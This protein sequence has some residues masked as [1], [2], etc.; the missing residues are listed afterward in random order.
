[1][2]ESTPM[3]RRGPWA[4]WC[5]TV[6][7]FF[8]FQGQ[9][10]KIRLEYKADSAILFVSGA[11]LQI[12]G[13]LFLAVLFT[14][15]PEVA[16][17]TLWELVLMLSAIY[18]TEGIVSFG[19]EGS[20]NLSFLVHSGEMERFLL[21]PV[22]PA[23]QIMTFTLGIHGL[24]N[25]AIGVGLFALAFQ[26]VAIVWDP[27]KVAFVPVFVVSAAALRTAISFASNCSAFW[28]KGFGN[29][30]P[31]MVHQA[32]DFAKYPG[33]IFG[34]G[35]QVFVTLVVPYAFLS[36]F[37]AVY[38]LGKES[39]GAVAWAVPLVALWAALVARWVFRA[40]LRRY[41]GPGN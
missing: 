31:L 16:G 1:M 38:L 24:G 8:R 32:A 33:G 30:F 29:A 11:T 10:L 13:F 36:Y 20:W 41:E 4:R 2:D 37:P 9:N 6:F 14:K 34:T 23:F 27:L 18:V 28:V 21:R 40:G 15:I 17:W 12:L 26:H 19:F 35:V 39:W 7:L 22:S 25:I 3:V 5:R